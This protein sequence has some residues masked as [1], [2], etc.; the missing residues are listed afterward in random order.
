MPALRIGIAAS[1][2]ARPLRAALQ[3]A[4]Q[5][6]ADGVELDLRTGLPTADMTPSAV[7]QLHKLLEDLRLAAPAAAFPT[8]RGF[9]DPEELDRRL[10]ATAAAIKSAAQLGARTLVLHAGRVA[11]EDAPS[12]TL[13]VDSLTMLTHQA[14][15]YGLSLAL[16]FRGEEASPAAQVLAA[17][18]QHIVGAC[19]DPAE[20]VAAGRDPQQVATDLRGRIN[21]LYAGD[22]VPGLGAAAATPVQLGRGSVEWPELLAALEEQEYRG[23]ATLRLRPGGQAEEL[24]DGL[25]Y[26]RTL[27]AG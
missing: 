9:G 17:L 11:D 20:L 18:P 16:I 6:D 26:L 2:L 24:A 8:R 25:A 7:R 22:A 14:D 1:S 5:F 21:H 27:N 3:L 10:A 4:S 23:W 19:L 15:H 13:M 12:R